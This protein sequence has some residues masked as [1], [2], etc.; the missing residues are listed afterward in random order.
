MASQSIQPDLKRTTCWLLPEDSEA[1]CPALLSRLCSRV[2]F[3]RLQPQADFQ[4]EINLPALAG[5]SSVRC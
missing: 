4:S 2:F 5:S 3:R 1:L